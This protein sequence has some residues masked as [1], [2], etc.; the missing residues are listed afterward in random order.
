[1]R[2][3]RIF[4]RK[5]SKKQMHHTKLFAGLAPLFAG[6]TLA[7]LTMPAVAE[8]PA[9][10]APAPGAPTIA[11]PV[12]AEPTQLKARTRPVPEKRKFTSDVIERAITAVSSRIA[13]PEVALLFQNCYPN[14]L[15]TA[16]TFT[17]TNGQPDTYI[18]TGDIN[19]MWLRDSCAEVQGY[20]PFCKQDPH[21]AQMIAGLIHRQA[22]YILIDPYANAFQQDASRPSPHRDNT[23]MRPGVFERKWELDSLCYPIRLAYQYWK[24]TGDKTPFDAH[25]WSAMRLAE[26]TMRDQQRKKDHGLYHFIRGRVAPGDE[27][28]GPPIKPTGMIC[29]LFRNSDDASTYLFNIP[30]NLFALSSLRELAEMSSAMMPRDPFAAECRA[31]A[32]EVQAGIQQYGIVNDPKYGKLYAFECDGLGHTLLVDDAGI[33]GLLTI[34]YL[35]PSLARDPLVLADRK[36]SLSP[37]DPYFYVGTVAQGVGSK[38]TS[39]GTIWPMGLISQAIT[40]TDDHEIASCLAM[41]NR[42]A[43][44]SGYMHELFNKDDAVKHTRDWFAWVNNFYGEMILK[45]MRDRP[46]VLTKPLPTGL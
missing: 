28:Y 27:G 14:T 24:I 41:L 46:E 23:D 15:D 44:G 4:L 29:T 35:D 3:L 8:P 21:L 40:S 25:W 45:V 22:T 6:L 42:S 11:A 33:P 1:M 16:V 20:L 12:P 43:A 19:A 2:G 5:Q 18:V 39:P 13:D 31:L 17:T 37:D 10:P 32:G 38:H 30:D 9:T 26:A 34:P 7:A 36:F